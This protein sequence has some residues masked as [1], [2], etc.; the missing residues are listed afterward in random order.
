MK[1]LLSATTGLALLISAD[2]A[3]ANRVFVTNE[4]SN[5]VTVIDGETF[6]VIGTY[7]VGNRPRGITISPDGSELY[8]CASDD[9]LVQHYDT[10]QDITRGNF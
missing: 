6:E 1:H 2:A 4:R 10:H 5:D 9:N 3:L 7:P 8:V